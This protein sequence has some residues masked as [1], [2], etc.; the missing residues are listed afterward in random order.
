M[1]RVVVIIADVSG[2]C[3]LDSMPKERRYKLKYC[4]KYTFRHD[5]CYCIVCSIVSCTSGIIHKHVVPYEVQGT[6]GGLLGVSFCIS[7]V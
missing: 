5:I 2:Q 6:G 1:Q 7:D 4:W 3:M